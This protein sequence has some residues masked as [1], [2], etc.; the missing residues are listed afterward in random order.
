M[1][2][3]GNESPPLGGLRASDTERER[4]V[5]FLRDN[6]ADGRLAAHELDERA[7]S[8]YR[9]ITIGQLE[10][11]V[12]DL[13]GSP[14]APEPPPAPPSAPRRS[15]FWQRFGAYIVDAIVLAVISSALGAVLGHAAH[16]LL[17]VP[18]WWAYATV[19]E[20]GRRGQ[21]VGK[22]VVGIRVVDV[23]TGGSIGYV[24]A[25][26]RQVVAVISAIPFFLGYLWMLWDSEHQCWHDKAA[27]D[28]VVPVRDYPV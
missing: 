19:L 7:E 28:V 6:A 12:A 11:L 10:A 8:A 21:T 15:G 24:R 1:S 9:A 23:D 4:V 3:T 17:G 26:I 13:P 27:G 14:L 5:A 16:G 20:G 18:L 2:A 25:F 22:M